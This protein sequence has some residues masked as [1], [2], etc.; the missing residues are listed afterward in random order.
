MEYT[1]ICLIGDNFFVNNCKVVL[2]IRLN[3]NFVN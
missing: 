3:N 1:K 2:K